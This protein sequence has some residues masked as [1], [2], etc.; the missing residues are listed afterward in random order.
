MQL[1]IFNLKKSACADD[2]DIMR[3][4]CSYNVH[5]VY[6]KIIC[7]YN[8]EKSL[9]KCGSISNNVGGCMGPDE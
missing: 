4:L 3:I 8:E 9:S 5:A 2:Q 6:V 1:L 7:I